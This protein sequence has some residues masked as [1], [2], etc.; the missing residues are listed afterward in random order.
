MTRRKK[1]STQESDPGERPDDREQ[2]EPAEQQDQLLY[3]SVH[4][5]K[6]QPVSSKTKEYQ[7]MVEYAAVTFKSARTEPRS[8]RQEPPEDPDA[9]YSRVS[10]SSR[11][12]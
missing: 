4:F 6:S 1:V 10:K 7:E 5:S 12:L 8:R 9:V 11:K 2:I 3:T